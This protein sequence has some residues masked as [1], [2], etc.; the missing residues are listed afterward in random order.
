MSSSG[1]KT[2]TNYYIQLPWLQKFFEDIVGLAKRVRQ[3]K[4]KT[5]SDDDRMRRLFENI[6]RAEDQFLHPENYPELKRM[7][8]L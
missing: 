3:L 7:G 8:L 5:S 2:T 6:D 1:Y 4:A